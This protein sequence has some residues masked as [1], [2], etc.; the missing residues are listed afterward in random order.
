MSKTYHLTV[1]VP[2]PT[3]TWAQ[4]WGHSLSQMLTDFRTPPSD[5]NSTSLIPLDSRGPSS[6]PTT[7]LST[8]RLHPSTPSVPFPSISLYTQ[9][10]VPK[11]NVFILPSFCSQTS[12]PSP[13]NAPNFR[14]CPLSYD[15]H[16]LFI[17]WV[18]GQA[19]PPAASL[20]LT[21]TRT[22]SRSSSSAAAA[23][24]APPT[25]GGAAEPAM[26]EAG[27]VVAIPPLLSALSW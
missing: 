8:P 23:A 4:G 2:P 19:G 15:S 3:S 20:T 27:E 9:V 24:W 11:T 13:S 1:F 22:T 25:G 10:C 26:S 12:A 21:R 7:Y 17:H 14:S 5:S 16:H 18:P 6:N